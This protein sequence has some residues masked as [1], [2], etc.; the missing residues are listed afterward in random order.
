MQHEL[1]VL[2][3]LRV[4]RGLKTIREIFE[5]IEQGN[6]IFDPFS[7]LIS[8]ESEIG[9]GNTIHSCVSLLSGDASILRIGNDNI[10]HPNTVLVAEGGDIL[11]GSHN[12]FGEGGFTAKANKPG[13]RI[14]IGSHGRYL[15]NA[16]VFG[17]TS[18]GDGC[19]ILGQITVDSC[20]LT[21]GGCWKDP[22]P[23]MRGALL[24]GQ[25]NA[26]D[27]SLETGQVIAGQGCF[28]QKDVLMQS[29]FHPPMAPQP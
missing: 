28:A 14:T 8:V 3:S 5:L 26:R 12:Q 23:D 20:S 2:D 11:V 18:L 10:F 25:G 24:K 15:G 7:V 6:S 9:T 22:D 1:P 29:H 27:I 21:G 13:A 17:T 4:A 19:Q 16:T